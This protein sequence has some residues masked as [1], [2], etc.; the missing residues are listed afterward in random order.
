MA[1]LSCERVL[2]RGDAPAGGRRPDRV[3]AAPARAEAN[4][5]ATVGGMPMETLSQA[6][7]RLTVAGYEHDF[8]AE[9]DGLRAVGTACV[10]RPES[11]VIEE[12]LRFEGQSDPQDEATLFALRCELHGT[13]GTYVVTFG[14]GVDPVDAE[15]VHRLADGRRP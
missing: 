10:H 6:L 14:P 7:E 5:V 12:A 2:L 11:L 3:P 13:R 15:R 1:F 8:R 9:P 4:C